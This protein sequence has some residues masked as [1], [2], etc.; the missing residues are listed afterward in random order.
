MQ[1]GFITVKDPTE[2]GR[3]TMVN[4]AFIE[5]IKVEDDFTVLQMRSGRI[6]YTEQ[7]RDAVWAG[8]TEVAEMLNG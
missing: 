1:L 8:I 7:P 2:D 6:H 5:A 3:E 4:V